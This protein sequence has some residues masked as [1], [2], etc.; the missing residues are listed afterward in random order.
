MTKFWHDPWCEYI[1]LKEAF[2]VLFGIARENDASIVDNLELL[3]G[4]NQW[5]VSFSRVA[6]H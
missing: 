5:S 4:S 3:G 2:L 1:A 6:H